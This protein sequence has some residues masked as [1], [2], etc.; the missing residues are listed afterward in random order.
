MEYRIHQ[1]LRISE[2]GIGCYALSGAY[3]SKDIPSFQDMLRRA[4][5]LGV[6]FFDTAEAYADAELVLGETVRPFR[7]EIIIATKVGGKVG[8]K[9]DLS[10]EYIREAC[11]QSLSALQ[12]DYI[13][14][15]QLHFDDLKTPVDEVLSTLDELIGEGKI[16]RY[17]VGHLPIEKIRAYFERGKVFSV[18][19]E[20]SAVERSALKELLPICMEHHVGL[21]AHGTTGRG[22]L[23][24]RFKHG[25]SFEPGDLRGIDPLFQRERFQF[26]LL[27]ADK[28][29]EFG[30]RYG[31]TPSQAAIAWV[32][33][34]PGVVCALS[35]PSTIPHLEEN[36]GA[37]GWSFSPADLT[38]LDAFLQEQQPALERQQEQSIRT[39]LNQPLE[40]DAREAFTSLVYAIDTAVMLGLAPQKQMMPVFYDLLDIM[41]KLHEQ[42]ILEQLNQV[43]S[44]ARDAVR[45]G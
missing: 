24:G 18:L 3:G 20:L 41:K 34:R 7:K 37:S 9:P 11:N 6:N 22:L 33:S 19:Y 10:R 14:L 31:K 15:Y 40:Q 4:Y 32:L 21:I 13:D 8:S 38:E 12:T 43:Q 35:G 36:L 25:K 28:L 26:G 1:E 45:R 29:A 23:S 17:G 2:I 16:R 27:V 44:R 42:G 39:I 5:E 30:A